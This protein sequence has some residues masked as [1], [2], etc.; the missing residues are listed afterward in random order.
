MR[1][2]EREKPW[3]IGSTSLGAGRSRPV[4]PGPPCRLT[5][6]TATQGSRTAWLVRSEMQEWAGAG[7]TAKSPAGPE[8]L[9]LSTLS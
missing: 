8:N 3:K 2:R 4:H 1:E 6:A 9:L 5:E 7:I